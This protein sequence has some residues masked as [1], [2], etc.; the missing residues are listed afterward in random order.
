MKINVSL[1]GRFHGFDLANGLYEAGCLNKLFTSYPKFFFDRYLIS[2]GAIIN[3]PIFEV[4]ER[5]IQK[6]PTLRR[7]SDFI[8]TIIP[9]SF[10]NFVSRHLKADFDIFVGW[11]SFSLSSIGKAKSL[12]KISVLERGSTH[13][14]WQTKQLTKEFNIFNRTFN[15]TNKAIISKELLEYDTA[16]YIC[17]PTNFVKSTFIEYGIC[18]EKIFV[19]P[20]GVNPIEFKY[21]PKKSNKFIIIFC[22]GITLRKGAQYLIRA[23]NKLALVDAE[24]WFVGKIDPYFREIFAEEMGRPN[25]KFKGAFPQKELCEIYNQANVFCLPSLEEGQAMVLHQ[26]MR[27]GLPIIA[28]EESGAA[29]LID[30][31]GYIINARSIDS[32]ADRI[33]YLYDHHSILESAS[34]RSIEL[35]QGQYSWK[36]YTQRAINIYKSII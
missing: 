22:G 24:L 25:I 12:N 36:D 2:K 1:R 32:I 9:N 19:N 21:I 15:E 13:I 5:I 16:D 6:F 8:S 7:N 17:V 4:S 14:L 27:C 10:D 29:D 34:K 11:S 35:S 23:F 26:A 20:Y 28:T 3:A 30:G 33:Q 18:A 31:N